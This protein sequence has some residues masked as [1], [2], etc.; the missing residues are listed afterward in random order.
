MVAQAESG[1]RRHGSS[2]LMIKQGCLLRC[3]QLQLPCVKMLALRSTAAGCVAATS[4]S[5]RVVGFD[6]LHAVHVTLQGDEEAVNTMMEGGGD[7]LARTGARC[8]GHLG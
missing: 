2:R 1:A 5:S 7:V 8:G 3:C 4:T 6:C